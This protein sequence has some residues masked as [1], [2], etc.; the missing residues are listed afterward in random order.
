MEIIKQILGWMIIIGTFITYS[1][2]YKKLYDI[3]DINGINDNM[4]LLGCASSAFN[5]MGIIGNNLTILPKYT[6]AELYYKLLPII[7]ILSPWL[8]LQINYLIYYIY[9]KNTYNR[10]KFVYFNI[11]LIIILLIIF[12]I[13]AVYMYSNYNGLSDFLNCIS[14]IMSIAM[15]VPQIITTWKNKKEGSLSL[16]SLGCH[17]VG[18]LL[19]IVF[20]FLEKQSF[21]TILPYIVALGCEGWLVG[22]CL[23]IKYINYKDLPLLTL[24]E[25]YNDY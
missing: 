4:L 13:T 2:Q 7:Q 12:P 23:R 10:K 14:T 22:Y 1:F 11:V 20:Q 3:K 8:C 18:C 21:T 19:V 15:W 5:L 16:L 17:S 9:E 6:H 25:N 24:D